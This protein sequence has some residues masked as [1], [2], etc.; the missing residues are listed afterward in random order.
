M[1]LSR[2]FSFYELYEL[3]QGIFGYKIAFFRV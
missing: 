2:F 1:I 3:F